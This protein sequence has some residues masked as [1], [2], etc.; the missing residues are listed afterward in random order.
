MGER[1]EG[2]CCEERLQ[3]KAAKDAEGRKGMI[4][5]KFLNMNWGLEFKI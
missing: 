3:R 2:K 1:W 4:D 5:I